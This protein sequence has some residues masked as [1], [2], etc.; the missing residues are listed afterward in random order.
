MKFALLFQI[1]LLASL[2]A[3]IVPAN[4]FH[5]S[6]VPSYTPGVK[7]GDTVAYGNVS[8]FWR[9]NVGAPAPPFVAEFVN[10][11]SVNV[12]VQSVSGS[13]ITAVQTFKFNNGT[14]PRT[15]DLRGSVAD[16]SGNLTFWVLS[17][18]LTTGDPIYS[19]PGVPRI[20]STDTLPFAG[21]FREVIHLNFILN[22]GALQLNWAWDQATG[23]LLS[24]DSYT[25]PANG[26]NSFFGYSIAAITSTSLWAFTPTPNFSIST[27]PNILTVFINN[28][29][30][31]SSIITLTSQN[32]TGPIQLSANVNPSGLAVQLGSPN[33]FLNLNGQNTT[34]LTPIPSIFTNPGTY[35]VTVIGTTGSLSQTAIITVLVSNTLGDFR[36]TA[37][38]TSI[39][40]H[41]A[42]FYDPFAFAT[43][44]I[45]LTSLSGFSGNLFLS[46]AEVNGS[47]GGFGLTLNPSLVSLTLSATANS[48]LTVSAPNTAPGT[49]LINVTATRFF[50]GT[51]PRSVSHSVTITVQVVTPPPDFQL[52]LSIPPAGNVIVAGGSTSVSIQLFSTGFNVFN[53]TVT[54]TGQV[55]PSLN[56]GPTFSFNPTQISL[57][58]PTSSFSILTI[59]TSAATPPGNYTVTVTGSSGP[60]VHVLMFELTV[61]PAPVLTLTPSSGSLGTMVTVHGSGFLV[62]SQRQFFSPVELEMTFDNQLLGFIFLQNSSFSFTFDVPHAQPGIVHQVHAIELFPFNLDVQAGF[63]VLPEPSILSVNVSVGSIYFPGDAAT[64]FAMT[65]INGQPT[66]V[67]GLQ[68]ILIAPNGSNITLNTVLVSPGLYKAS[69]AVPATGSMGT[70]AV[71]A[72]AQRTSSGDGSALASFEVKPTWLQANGRNVITATSIVGAV[73]TLGVVALAWR[74]GYFTRRKD[75]FPIP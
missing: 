30:L 54:L 1:L 9:S 34:T 17:S 29:F 2:L 24:F 37:N 50:N 53:G 63:L 31:S 48:T 26:D 60:R 33:L 51:L 44:T 73:G 62:S 59:S 38:P 56:N 57:V 40:I 55:S 36:I 23:V 45:S 10:V 14:G 22:S 13:N 64:I 32:F 69:Y 65:S 6:A 61:L 72:R 11:T 46:A 15:F 52:F 8:T 75:E 74:K 20:N 39:T 43:S 47:S 41:K 35:Q 4:V 70:Y 71:I 18:G 42:R 7:F 28:S 16:G 68:V 66:T 25:A 12:A 3:L 21:A 67:T 27:N 49:Y 5:V 58:L 19:I